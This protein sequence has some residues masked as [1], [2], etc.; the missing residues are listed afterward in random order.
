MQN[1]QRREI[2]L[3]VPAAPPAKDGGTSIR[4]PG[5]DHRHLVAALRGAMAEAMRD[6]E[7]FEGERLGMELR[8]QRGQCK[9]D[10]LNLINGVADVIQRHCTWAEY[11]YDVWVFDNDANVRE[12]HFSEEPAVQ[13]AYE[14][15]VYPIEQEARVPVVSFVLDD[16]D[17]RFAAQQ[18]YV[19]M[20][21][22]AKFSFFCD[23]WPAG[24]PDAPGVYLIWNKADELVYVG[25]TANLRARMR[26]IGRT[27]NHSCRR[28]VGGLEFKGTLDPKTDLYSPEI[29]GL[30]TAF[31]K[32]ELKVA[33][34]EVT[35]GRKELEFF[36]MAEH[37]SDPKFWPK[38]NG[39]LKRGKKTKRAVIRDKVVD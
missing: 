13:D 5:H 28:K 9:A 22:E 6:E 16:E 21:K 39:T 37:H 7:P 1:Q 27:Y 15:R 25:E 19:R 24:V 34:A 3:R 23:D 32:D 36:F 33:F 4:S 20:A 30:T 14:V 26:D 10:A 31:F 29:E 38:Y 11:R 17:F 12:F 2:V 35:I 8:L 18:L